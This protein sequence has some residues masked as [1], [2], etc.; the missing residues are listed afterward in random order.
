[1]HD[2]SLL[3]LRDVVVFYNKGGVPHPGLD[4]AIQPLGLSD[5]EVGDLVA[6]LTSLTAGNLEELVKD[7]RS[8]KVG[9]V[10]D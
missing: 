1:M 5:A 8:V 7:A 3:T 6:F 2:G 10:G 4:P 9:N